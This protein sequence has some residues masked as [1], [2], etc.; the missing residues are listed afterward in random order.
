MHHV[1][2]RWRFAKPVDP[3]SPH[4][5]ELSAASRLVTRSGACLR[6][7]SPGLKSRVAQCH[8]SQLEVAPS[9]QTFASQPAVRYTPDLAGVLIDGV[10]FGLPQPEVPCVAKPLPEETEE[11]CSQEAAKARVS[12]ANH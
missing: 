11:D 9:V 12:H 5:L 8:E 6:G 10:H 3:A 2:G 7:R 4:G 1:P